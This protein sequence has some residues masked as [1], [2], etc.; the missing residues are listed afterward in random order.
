MPLAPDPHTANANHHW[1]LAIRGVTG[2]GVT[3]RC[4]A[5]I[6]GTSCA[7]LTPICGLADCS[8]LVMYL[9]A[10][11]ITKADK[12]RELLRVIG[13]RGE[14]DAARMPDGPLITTA[15]RSLPALVRALRIGGSGRGADSFKLAA[16]DEVVGAF[17]CPTSAPS[18]KQG[19]KVLVGGFGNRSQ[20]Q[21]LNPRP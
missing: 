18:S 15:E 4:R 7:T 9:S 14:G 2:R 11:P 16:L 8:Y 12:T 5:S 19:Q 21:S 13:T 10:R 17:R 1:L 20:T 3:G 6:P